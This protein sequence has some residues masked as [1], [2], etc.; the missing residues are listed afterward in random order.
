MKRP[1]K[2]KVERPEPICETHSEIAR[3]GQRYEKG[4]NDACNDWEKFLPDKEEILSILKDRSLFLTSK[5]A[6]AI[7]KRIGKEV[8]K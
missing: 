3:Y 1:E 7:V 6:E 8:K 4:Y 5:V 2:K